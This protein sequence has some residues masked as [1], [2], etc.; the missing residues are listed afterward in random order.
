MPPICTGIQF[1]GDRPTADHPLPLYVQLAD[2]VAAQIADGVHPAGGEIPSIRRLR[3]Q[4]GISTTTAVEACRLLESRGLVRARPRSGYFVERPS[5]GRAAGARC[6]HRPDAGPPRRRRPV[7]EAEPRDRQPA[8]THPRGRGPGPRTDGH[9]LVEPPDRSG[10]APAADRVPLLRRAA[11]QPGPAPSR[12]PTRP[13]RR[14]RGLARRHRRHQRR[15]GSGLPVDPRRHPSGRHGGHREPR[16][17]RPARGA[18]VAATARGGGPG[19]SAPGHRP[20]CARQGAGPPT[21][22]GGRDRLELLQPVRL[23]HGRRRQA[24]AGRAARRPRRPA[25]GGRRLRRPGLRRDL[26]RRR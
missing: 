2:V 18:R 12:R 25:G 23:V 22:R 16:L 8:T 3:E 21:D 4:H 26:A 17:L 1:A 19:P 5:A 15:Q 10:A 11:G 6:P 13:R 7:D 24:G 9:P 20:G 14:V